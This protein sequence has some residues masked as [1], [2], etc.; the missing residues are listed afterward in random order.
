MEQNKSKEL[1]RRYLQEICNEGNF[2]VAD[3]ILAPGIVFENP[4]VRLEGIE[5]FKGLITALR[6]AF[7]DFEFIIEDEVAEGRKVAT[8][9]RLRGTQHGEF[10]G[11]P[12]THK[13]F[14]VTGIDIFEIAE[15]RI[16]RIWVN[17]DL[18]GQALQL[19]WI[20]NP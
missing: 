19:G 12:P 14:D 3:D 7:P 6:T 11:N 16:E 18:L 1:A 2:T 9:W 20:P 10:R 5:A 15:G 17:M 8:R 4:P 13:Q